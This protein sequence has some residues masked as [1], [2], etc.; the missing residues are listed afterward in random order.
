MQM[1]AEYRDYDACGLAK[2]LDEKQ[3]TPL[4][5]MEA[6]IDRAGIVNPVLN[7]LCYERFEESLDIARRATSSGP[8]GA[9]PFL[10]KDSIPSARFP[11]SLG[12]RFFRDVS[13]H[14]D[15]ELVTRCQAAGFIPFARTTV[16]E[17]LLSTATEAA[18]NG[19]P[20]RNPWSLTHSPGGSSGGAAAAVAAGIVPI[21]HASD[22]LGSIRVPASCCGLFGLKPSRGRLPTGPFAAEIRAGLGTDGFLSRTVRDTAMALDAVSGPDV[23]A[24]YA[25]YGPP[26]RYMDALQ[27][28]RA[29][30][31]RIAVWRDPW[32][33]IPVHPDC[34]EAVETCAEI[35]GDLGHHLDLEDPVA[36]DFPGYMAAISRVFASFMVADI[37]LRGQLSGRTP[38][39]ADFERTTWTFYEFGRTL[40]AADYIRAIGAVQRA[41]RQLSR[42]MADFDVVLTPTL[43]RPPARLGEISMAVD[44]AVHERASF[45]YAAFTTLVNASGQ[46]AASVPIARNPEGLPIGVQIIGQG[47]REDVLLRLAT[48]IEAAA[49]WTDRRPAI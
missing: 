1:F 43:S 19:A 40:C 48:E 35:C 36:I 12:S 41:G 16:P 39:E 45:E 5:L 7:V 23:G 24:P 34:L 8:F 27:Q 20:T 14:Q 2:L 33:L 21:A 15:A 37:E 47:G 6:A 31:L 28:R 13:L 44:F 11:A 38:T 29:E 25:A 49:P 10:L 4:D 30:P 3:V 18:A 32:G 42:Y 46:P 26:G 17:L 9:L 22:G